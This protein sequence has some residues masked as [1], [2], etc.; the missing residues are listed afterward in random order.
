MVV[1]QRGVGDGVGSVRAVGDGLLRRV[2][3]V[4]SDQ[5]DGKFLA[6]G[7]GQCTAG[8]EQFLGGGGQFAARGLAKY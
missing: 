5:S 7:V 8:G 4:R 1:S 3:Q 2:G 6:Q